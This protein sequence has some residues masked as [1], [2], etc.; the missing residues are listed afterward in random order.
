MSLFLALLLAIA[1]VSGATASVVGF[2]IGSLLTP[3]LAARTGMDVAVA[4]V[5]IPHFVATALRCWRLRRSIDRAVLAR[6]G[7]LSAVGGLA[8][9]LL[10]A[11][12]GSGAL[13][14]DLGA[15]LVHTAIVQ[16]TG[17]AARWRPR[18]AA[19]SMLGL[20]SGLFGG[21]AGNQGGLRAAAL[22]AFDLTPAAFVATSTA[23]ALVVD[24]ARAP[25]YLV[26]AGGR[27]VLLLGP[28]A[29][30]TVGVVIGT[31]VGERILLGLSRQVFVRV[32][33]T[34]VGVLGIWHL[35]S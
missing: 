8:G 34:A 28:I 20:A 31:L 13:T 2:G 25:V 3:V 16:L 6:F 33:G 24:L 32:V 29:L 14:R 12:L 18:G 30:A 9:A 7:A 15:L 26:T 11:R 35:V 1:I 5:A 21:V 17:L 22:G 19:V 10:Y 23:I 4:F 27:L